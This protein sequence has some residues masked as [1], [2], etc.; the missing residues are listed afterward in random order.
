[1]PAESKEIGASA[2]R[3]DEV[4][5]IEDDVSKIAEEEDE[6]EEED[7]MDESERDDVD[8]EGVAVQQCLSPCADKRTKCLE[9]S[10]VAQFAWSQCSQSCWQS[11]SKC[12][13]ECQ[14]LTGKEDRQS[15]VSSC[16]RRF[17]ECRG[18]CRS[19]QQA[20]HVCHRDVWAKCRDECKPRS[21]SCNTQFSR[22]QRYAGGT[23]FKTSW[24]CISPCLAAKERCSASC[25]TKT[26]EARRSCLVTCAGPFSQCRSTCQA[27][28]ASAQRCHRE[29]WRKCQR[30]LNDSASKGS[31]SCSASCN[32]QR[33]ACHQGAGVADFSVSMCASSCR[34]AEARCQ[35]SCGA[36]DHGCLRA[37][38]H[39]HGSCAAA[40]QV[41]RSARRMCHH[42]GWRACH[43]ACSSLTTPLMSLSPPR[44]LAAPEK[45]AELAE[46]T[47]FDT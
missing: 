14:S 42:E 4:S 19:K 36:A 20:R 37:C 5:D 44:H 11:S 39:A 46:L 2:G 32:D 17:G 15:C 3:S 25:S 7:E 35:G 33:A 1:M 21:L 27:K 12:K 6:Q 30:S 26:G 47:E 43:A 24:S 31:P 29:V 41:K 18:E 23:N 13:A 22:C 34:I 40:C 8:H 9:A 28:R 10:G 38:A 45:A 16:R